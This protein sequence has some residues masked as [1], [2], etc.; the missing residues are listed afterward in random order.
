[1]QKNET[2]LSSGLTQVI[3]QAARRQRRGGAQSPTPRSP[4]TLSIKPTLGDS[5]K[6]QARIAETHQDFLKICQTD[7]QMHSNI[8]QKKMQVS[9]AQEM[10]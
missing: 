10:R 8:S 3:L 7:V 6:T 2:T 1:M 9:V 5:K 4:T